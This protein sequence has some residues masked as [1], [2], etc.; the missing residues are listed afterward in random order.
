V[1]L[2]SCHF[3]SLEIRHHLFDVAYRK[4]ILDLK[5]YI[6]NTWREIG[7]EYIR[8]VKGGPERCET[9]ACEGG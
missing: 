2:R 5:T 9:E 6:R 8:S 3:N 4:E 1:V 7:Q